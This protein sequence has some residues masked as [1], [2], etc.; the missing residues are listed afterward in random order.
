[1]RC[2]VSRLCRYRRSVDVA[3]LR[4]KAG[5]IIKECIQGMW[6]SMG[7]DAVLLECKEP[8]AQW[9]RHAAWY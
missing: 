5:C 1:M 3:A 4:G 8:K 9:V 7:N 2:R 6:G